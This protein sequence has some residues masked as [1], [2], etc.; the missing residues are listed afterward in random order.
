MKRFSQPAGGENAFQEFAESWSMDFYATRIILFLIC[1]NV[2]I[3]IVS[4]LID[5]DMFE[6]SYNDLKFMVW[7]CTYI[8]TNLICEVF[9]ML[10]N[11][12]VV[13]IS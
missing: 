11:L 9:Y 1:K 2:L 13:I 6:P 5:K 12:I 3:L 7:N 4:I 10:I 8:C